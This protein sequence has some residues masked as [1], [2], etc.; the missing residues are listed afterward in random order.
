[1]IAF[2][3]IRWGG[4]ISRILIIGS[5]GFIGSHLTRR[6]RESNFIVDTFPATQSDF[7][8]QSFPYT[9]LDYIS[10][11]NNYDVVIDCIGLKKIFYNTKIDFHTSLTSALHY[12]ERLLNYFNTPEK[13]FYFISSGG[14]VYGNYNSSPIPESAKLNGIT[15][16]AKANI[17]IE[18]LLL[19]FGNSIILRGANVFGEIK[20]NKLRQGLITEL[21]YSAIERYVVTINSLKTVK[22]FIFIDDFVNILI[23]LFRS[24]T[25]PGIYNIGTGTGTAVKEIIKIMSTILIKDGRELH[26]VVE[27]DNNLMIKNILDI[28]KLNS[29]IGKYNFLP[30]DVALDLTWNRIYHRRDI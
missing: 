18:T 12:Y 14:S 28:S 20:P 19:S 3:A 15:P 21:Y 10:L 7:I 8:T 4:I 9:L 5:G 2:S 22:D 1:M 6:V 30:L 16:Y 26:Y 27:D 25:Q 24:N 17:E 29:V 13:K 11:Q 23:K